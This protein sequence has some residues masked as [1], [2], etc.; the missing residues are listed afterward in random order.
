METAK[1]ALKM[2]YTQGGTRQKVE[3]IYKKLLCIYSYMFKLQSTLHLMQYTYWDVF[4]TAQTVFELVD[5]DAFF[6]FLL[7]LFHMDK[8]FSSED[9]FHVG[10]QTKKS[11]K[12][13]SDE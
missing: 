6:F 8:M 5:F 2:C 12:V 9:F 7:H 13:K 1:T 3:F 10:K 4:S 11:F